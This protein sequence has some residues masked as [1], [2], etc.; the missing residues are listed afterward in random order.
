MTF[1][2]T[3]SIGVLGAVLASCASQPPPPLPPPARMAD[4]EDVPGGYQC[5]G[6]PVEFSPMRSGSTSTG[7]TVAE[8]D[9]EEA[10]WQAQAEAQ[11]AAA[12]AARARAAAVRARRSSEDAALDAD[13]NRS[14][15]RAY[16]GAQ[17]VRTM[18]GAEVSIRDSLGSAA[19]IVKLNSIGCT[20]QRAMLKYLACFEPIERPGKFDRRIRMGH[21]VP[22]VASP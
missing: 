14:V 18:T 2:K 8:M 15:D 5:G 7:T 13:L 20:A 11:G 1:R 21:L 12:K 22:V 6:T 9:Q 10:E 17:C 3:L 19:R 4:C 16:R